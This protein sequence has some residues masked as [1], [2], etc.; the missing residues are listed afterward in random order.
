VPCHVGYR[1]K[2]QA[3]GTVAGNRIT[4][5]TST[6]NPTLKG[7]LHRRFTSA[8]IGKSVRIVVNSAAFRSSDQNLT[9]AGTYIESGA[10]FLLS[11]LLALV[12][13]AVRGRVKR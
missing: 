6:S 1:Q 2:L 8:R 9:A 7:S 4:L 11:I 12:I 3:T 13:L 5:N 10:R